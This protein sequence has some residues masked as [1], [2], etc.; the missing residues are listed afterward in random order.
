MYPAVE[1]RS[2]GPPRLPPHKLVD[3]FRIFNLELPERSNILKKFQERYTPRGHDHNLSLEWRGTAQ[4]YYVKFIKTNPRFLNKPI[5]FLDTEEPKAKEGHWWP[6]SEPLVHR[7]KPSYDKQSSQ[8]IDF[9]KPNCKLSRPIKYCSLMLPSRGI[10]PLAFPETLT[11]LPNIFQEKISFKHHYNARA[12][13]CIPYQGKRQG[14]FVWQEIKPARGTPVPEGAEA[15]TNTQGSVLLEQ[16]QTEKGNSVENCM[17]SPCLS[18]PDSQETP[19]SDTGLSK[20]DIG[21]R[22]KADPSAP[23]KGQKSV[24][25]SQENKGDLS[26]P[27]GEAPS[28]P[29]GYMATPEA[30]CSLRPRRAASPKRHGKGSHTVP[31]NRHEGT[32]GRTAPPSESEG[33]HFPVTPFECPVEAISQGTTRH[34]ASTHLT[35]CMISDP[36]EAF[37][38]SAIKDCSSGIAKVTRPAQLFAPLY[39]AR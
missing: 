32:T 12:T 11:S 20:T 23:E 21:E 10:V 5:G 36:S 33:I 14:A 19:D 27:A 13:P 38:I 24:G 28:R 2:E 6:C 4:P 1:L 9:Q 25:I 22:A 34:V 17:T 29:T 30:M 39:L 16:P 26:C 37:L 3:T 31:Q 18:L 8:R 7:P 35:I 15:L